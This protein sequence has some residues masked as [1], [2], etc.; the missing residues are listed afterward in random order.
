M[1]FDA[2][3]PFKNIPRP[4]KINLDLL[5]IILY[6]EEMFQYTSDLLLNVFD[7]IPKLNDNIS[8]LNLCFNYRSNF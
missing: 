7:K 3:K 6:H 2:L 4:K 8:M 1:F 5:A